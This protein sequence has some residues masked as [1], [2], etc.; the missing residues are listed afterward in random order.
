MRETDNKQAS[1]N[2][3]C[4]R[5]IKSTEKRKKKKLMGHLGKK[6]LGCLGRKVDPTLPRAIRTGLPEGPQGKSCYSLCVPWI[7]PPVP[8]DLPSSLSTLTARR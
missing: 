5:V 7:V 8:M 4:Q 1:N 3:A 6:V 2:I